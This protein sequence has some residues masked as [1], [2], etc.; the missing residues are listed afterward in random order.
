MTPYSTVTEPEPDDAED[1]PYA[2]YNIFDECDEY[3]DYDGDLPF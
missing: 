1:D 3:E 2:D